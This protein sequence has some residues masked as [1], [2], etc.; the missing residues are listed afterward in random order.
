MNVAMQRQLIALIARVVREETPEKYR[1]LLVISNKSGPG[2]V[3]M[4][5][6]L[7]GEVLIYLNTK[8]PELD[9]AAGSKVQPFRGPGGKLFVEKIEK[10][11]WVDVRRRL[12]GV[13]DHYELNLPLEGIRGVSVHRERGG[14]VTLRLEGLSEGGYRRMVAELGPLMSL[15][16]FQR[17]EPV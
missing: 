14:G 11:L 4:D 9:I 1:G 3:C 8:G 15:S 17:E 7:G 12:P 16:R 6:R 13:I 2:Y 5:I 10:A